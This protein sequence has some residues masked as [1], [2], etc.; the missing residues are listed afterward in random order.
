VVCNDGVFNPTTVLN[1]R[2][3][4][5]VKKLKCFR[6]HLVLLKLIPARIADTIITQYS[7]VR[8]VVGTLDVTTLPALDA[9][10]VN[11]VKVP[12]FKEC[13]SLLKIVLSLSHG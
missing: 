9:F 11:I 5:L 13:S 7:S 6:Q 4:S 2:E 10:F 1:C 12:N 3:S 8:N